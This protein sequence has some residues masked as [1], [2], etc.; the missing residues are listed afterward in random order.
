MSAAH[1]FL[2]NLALVLCAAALMTV[3][4]QRLHQ[5]V[6]LGYVL[7]GVL[8]GPHV[9]FPLVAGEEVVHEL[10]D[11]GVILLVFFLGLEFDLMKLARM[12]PG[13]AF[14]AVVQVSI[15]MALGYAVTRA[16]GWTVREGLFAGAMIAISSSTIVAK[17]FDEQHVTGKLRETVLAALL[18]EDLVAVFLLAILTPIGSG[19]GFSP[20]TLLRT[21]ARLAGFLVVLIGGGLLVVPRMMRA[22]IRLG[23]SETTTIAAVGVCFALSYLAHRAGYSVALGAFIAGVLVSESGEAIQVEL[24][25]KPIRDVFAA[26]FFVAAGMLIE[27]RLVA[28]HFAAIIVLTAVVVVGKV[29]AVS[30]GELLAGSPVRLSVQAGM[31]MAQV[32]E[33]SFI[34][35]EVG[36]TLGAT[37]EFLYPVA[38]AVSVLTT[39]LSPWLLRAAGRTA[40]WLDRSLPAPLVTLATLY[41]DWVERLHAPPA[42]GQRHGLRRPITALVLDAGSLALVIVVA[43]LWRDR[44]TAQLQGALHVDPPVARAIVP[45]AAAVACIPLVLGLVRTARRIGQL[46]AARALPTTAEGVLDLAA[47]PRRALVVTLQL[48]V[49]LVVGAPLVVVTQSFVAP[50]LGPA[51]LALVLAALAVP[52]WRNATELEGHVRAGAHMLAGVLA[53]QAHANRGITHELDAAGRTLPGLGDPRAFHLSEGAHAVG[54]TLAELDLRTRTGASVLAI[55]RERQEIAAPRGG[56]RLEA[57]DVLALAGSRAAVAAACRLLESG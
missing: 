48:G 39:L 25:V 41:G 37:R 40:S 36:V 18:V 23:R 45:L 16:L 56:V 4:F 54:K 38:A 42:P 51:A 19:T 33:F 34:I 3:L 1:G 13:A 28:R 12:G 49:L 6:V 22:V 27:P 32:G 46:L 55:V 17:T 30:F 20:G 10:A 50:Y 9:P 29:V 57:R 44:M 47:A 43:A 15:M 21:A 2:D 7:A 52:L 5:P 35:A 31:S 53:E 11:L 26:V 14:V 24:L 8:I